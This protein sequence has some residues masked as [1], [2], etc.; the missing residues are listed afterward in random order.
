MPLDAGP[1]RALQLG[2]AVWLLAEVFI[3][4]TLRVEGY[5]GYWYLSNAWFLAGGDVSRYEPTKAPLLSL[6][7]L[8]LFALRAAGLPERA[9]FALAHLVSLGLTLATGLLLGR[10]LRQRFSPSIASAGAFAF[11]GSRVVFR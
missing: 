8:P 5:D 2:F 7:Y 11:L 1:R 6:L 9:V 3:A 10:V 4:L